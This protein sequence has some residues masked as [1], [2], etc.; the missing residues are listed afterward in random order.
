MASITGLLGLRQYLATR[1]EIFFEARAHDQITKHFN[2]IPTFSKPIAI[3]T[4]TQFL[5]QDTLL[6]SPKN[7]DVHTRNHHRQQPQAFNLLNQLLEKK[8][9][10]LQLDVTP[11]ETETPFIMA[12]IG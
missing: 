1:L 12:K 9:Q 6:Q 7:L 8:Y 4:T 3:I 11:I 2:R 5:L 10:K